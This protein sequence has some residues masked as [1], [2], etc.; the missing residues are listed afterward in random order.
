MKVSK[1]LKYSE[2]YSG[3]KTINFGFEETD[4]FNLSEQET[5][6]SIDMNKGNEVS[7]IKKEDC[8]KYFKAMTGYSPSEFLKIW[9]DSVDILEEFQREDN[10]KYK[11]GEGE[12]LISLAKLI[13]LNKQF[14]YQNVRFKII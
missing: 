14:S 8:F 5:M 12:Y 2:A 3:N 1:Y 11:E 4:K 10:P 7:A 13:S 6:I 9:S